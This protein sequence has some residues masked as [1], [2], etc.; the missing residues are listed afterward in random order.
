M[1]YTPFDIEKKETDV[2]LLEKYNL[3]NLSFFPLLFQTGYLTIKKYDIFDGTIILDYPNKEVA[4]SFSMHILTELT[5][6]NHDKTNVLV[7]DFA[8]AISNL[9]IEKVIKNINHLFKVIPYTLLDDKEKF[10]HSIFYTVLKLL[11]VRI[12]SEILTIDGRIDAIVKT[13]TAII[14]IEFKID[15]SADVA[16]SQIKEK[17]YAE[18]YADDPRP[19]YLLGID[20]DTE[21]KRADDYRF[22]DY[23]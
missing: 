14:V 20:F 4:K 10:Y 3:K 6:G 5:S 2:G 8:K 17:G 19:K 9:E 1:E 11:G 18:K 23:K 16:L 15:Q 22:E 13:E 12:E 21:T 7:V